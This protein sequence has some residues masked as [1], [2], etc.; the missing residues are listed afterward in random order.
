MHDYGFRFCQA[1][2]YLALLGELQDFVGIGMSGGGFRASLYHLGTL[3]ALAEVGLKPC[4][5]DPE[6]SAS[7]E[8][9]FERVGIPLA[10]S[11]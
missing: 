10:E 2:M 6:Y 7:F 8:I 1:L 5:T 9:C 3:S 11:R 4:L